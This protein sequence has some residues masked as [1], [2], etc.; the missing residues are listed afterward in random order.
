MTDATTPGNSPTSPAAPTQPV[1]ARPVFIVSDG[2]GITAETFAHSILAQFEMRFRQIRVPFVD[3]VDKAYET[4]QRINEMYRT[5]N[6]R[7]IIFSTLVDARANEILRNC[8]GVI[9]DMFQTFIEPLE[10]EL[11]LKSM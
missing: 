5:D 9:L 11:G 6:I 8:Q 4:A 1:A 2:T 3:S 7:P 10:L